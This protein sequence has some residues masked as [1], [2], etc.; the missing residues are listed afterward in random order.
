M[1]GGVYFEAGVGD[2]PTR[3]VAGLAFENVARYG[4]NGNAGSIFSDDQLSET[5]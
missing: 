2:R 3:K 5:G 4:S 1:G